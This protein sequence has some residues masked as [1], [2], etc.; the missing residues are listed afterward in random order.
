MPKKLTQ[1]E[2]LAKAVAA[3]GKRYDYSGMVYVSLNNKIWI[4][5]P[6]HG[7]FEQSPAKHCT[8]QG[9]TKCGHISMKAL[10]TK[11]TNA[12]IDAARYVHGELYDYSQV[13]YKGNKQKVKI[14]CHKH[15]IFQQKPNMHVSRANGC[16]SCSQAKPLSNGDFLAR[17]HAAHGDKYDYS[18]VEY[19]GN[20]TKV[21]IICPKHGIVEIKAAS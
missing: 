15:G 7:P 2:F 20:K 5:C 12:F 6:Q 4:N 16:P 17:A 19:R 21:K 1:A 9:C 10:I 11:S 13:D 8:G 14:L 3:H 18:L